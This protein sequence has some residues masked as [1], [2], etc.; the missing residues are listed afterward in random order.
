MVIV[1]VMSNRGGLATND[2]IITVNCFETQRR[3]SGPPDGRI[4]ADRLMTGADELRGVNIP[5]YQ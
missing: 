2:V 4:R 1:L 3:M 5:Q